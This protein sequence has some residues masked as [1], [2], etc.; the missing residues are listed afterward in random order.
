MTYQQTGLSTST[1]E[2]ESDG[3]ARA[4]TELVPARDCGQDR[5]SIVRDHTE[6]RSYIDVP[7]DR[8]G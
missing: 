6:E 2:D 3:L 8:Q 4:I 5:I 1:S 7:A